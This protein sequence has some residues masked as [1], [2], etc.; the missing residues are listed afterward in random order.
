MRLKQNI[1]KLW[2]KLWDTAKEVLIQQF[3]AI[4]P[5]LNKMISNQ[6]INFPQ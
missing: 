1:A 4:M 6:Q 3:I 5:I 2:V